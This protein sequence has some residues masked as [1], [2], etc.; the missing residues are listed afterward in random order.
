M[1]PEASGVRIEQARSGEPSEMP[2]SP[3][4][5]NRRICENEY[6]PRGE[7]LEQSVCEELGHRFPRMRDC[8]I[9]ERTRDDDLG[10]RE[11]GVWRHLVCSP[12]LFGQLLD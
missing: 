7:W 6:G 8:L 1:T 12:R 4:E 11:L 2:I 9:L 5:P 3:A 10:A